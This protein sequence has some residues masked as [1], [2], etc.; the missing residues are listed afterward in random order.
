MDLTSASAAARFEVAGLHVDID[1][2]TLSGPDA[3]VSLTPTE[4]K[5]LR[6]LVHAKGEV[7]VAQ[8]MIRSVWR[9]DPSTGS[10]EMVRA[11]IRNLRSKLNKASGTDSFLETVHRRGY[12]LVRPFSS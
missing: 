7:V 12:R 9:I 6:C 3:V 4:M 8:E 1:A 2:H 11:H 5:L 10:R